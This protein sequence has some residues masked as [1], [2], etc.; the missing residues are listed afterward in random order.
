MSLP[1][2]VV[3]LMARGDDSCALLALF[4]VDGLDGFYAELKIEF[5]WIRV[6]VVNAS[7]VK[8]SKGGGTSHDTT[9]MKSWYHFHYF[10]GLETEIPRP[11]AS[12]LS[13]HCL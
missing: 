12:K 3:L 1:V 11:S 2:H 9:H 8:M 7:M 6:N 10:A 4:C 5:T 13:S